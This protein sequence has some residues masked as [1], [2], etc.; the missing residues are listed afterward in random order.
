M[1]SDTNKDVIGQLDAN[2]QEEKAPMYQV[3]IH[4]DDFTPKEFVINILE[5]FFFMDKK[6]AGY[7]MMEAHIQGVAGCGVF[8]KDFAE[9]KVSQVIDYAKTYEHPLICSMEVAV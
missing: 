7:V 9:S 1:S 5:K 6:R 3:L 8:V 2:T 4:N